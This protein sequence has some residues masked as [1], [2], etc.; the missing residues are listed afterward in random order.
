MRLNLKTHGK[1]TTVIDRIEQ[2]RHVFR[3]YLGAVV[4]AGLMTVAP[5]PALSSW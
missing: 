1:P 3:A 4:A 5:E 2:G